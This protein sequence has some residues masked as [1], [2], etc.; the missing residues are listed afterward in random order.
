VTVDRSVAA[1]PCRAWVVLT[2]VSLCSVQSPLSQ[3]ILNVAFPRLRAAFDGTPA[4]TLSWVISAYSITA[5]ATLVIA[6]VVS[7]RYGR[8][9]VLLIGGAGFALTSLLS[10]FAPS[11][12]VLVALRIAQAVFGA[13][14]T[15]AGASLVLREFPVTRRATA[16]AAWAASGS[17]ASAVGPTLGALLVDAG[18]WRWAFWVNIPFAVAGI[19]LVSVLVPEMDRERRPFPDLVS[20]PLILVSVSGIVLGVSQSAR[21]GW[22]DSRTIGSIVVGATIGALLVRRSSRH[23]RPLLDLEL[24]G[25]RS[26]RLAN[27]ASITFGSTFFAVFLGFP[28][29]TQEVWGF[30]VRSA[31]LLLLPIPIAGMVFNGLAGRFADTHGHR[32]VMV[33]GGLLQAAG[34]VVLTVGITEQ[35]NVALWLIA[36]TLIGLGTSLIW[37]AIFGNTVIGVPPDRYGEVTSINQTAQRMANAAGTAIAVSLIGERLGTGIGAY[38]RIFVLTVLGGLVA[39]V[40]GTFMGERRPRRGATAAAAVG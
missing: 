11:V 24:F 12:G 23:P 2:V 33:L 6:G 9:R 21:W 22:D 17:V 34:G 1:I 18:G 40:L 19:V 38:E 14:L 3:S 15:P 37:P 32:P 20:V 13:L 16:I 30:E 28:R 10:G 36:L 25:F 35:R 26:F 4:A 39:S 5:A 8:K 27:I 7:D 31:G 29:F